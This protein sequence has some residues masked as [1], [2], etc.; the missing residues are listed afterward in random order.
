MKLQ[1][2]FDQEGAL[3]LSAL[4]GSLLVG[5][6]MIPNFNNNLGALRIQADGQVF[7]I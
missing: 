2:R 5:L 6:P 4:S 3:L 1:S 7:L